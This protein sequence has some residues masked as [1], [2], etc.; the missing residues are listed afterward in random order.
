M[1]PVDGYPTRFNEFNDI[2]TR[3]PVTAYVP[4]TFEPPVM[5]PVFRSITLVLRI[6]PAPSV[7]KIP[8][9]ASAEVPLNPAMVKA[10]EL[11]TGAV[12]IRYAS[13]VT[14][15]GKLLMSLK[16]VESTGMQLNPTNPSAVENC[17]KPRPSPA[18]SPMA[19]AGPGKMG[20]L[21]VITPPSFVS[22]VP[23]RTWPASSAL[24]TPAD[25]RGF[26]VTAFVP[27]TLNAKVPGIN[28]LLKRVA[29]CLS[30]APSELAAFSN[31]T[32]DP[33][34]ADASTTSNMIGPRICESRLKLTCPAGLTA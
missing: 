2:V 13:P 25:A 32:S 29:S 15:P 12:V 6:F 1:P 27:R 33:C 20:E 14:I 24:N 34:S 19:E 18:T 8:P 11:G 5:P 23:L 26:P 31:R 10:I 7:F 22:T 21:L 28:D 9:V 30:S 4:V 16:C 17:K 3:F